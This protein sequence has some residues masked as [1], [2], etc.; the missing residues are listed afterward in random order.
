MSKIFEIL[1]KGITEN[2][3]ISIPVS[4][5][6]GVLS[7]LLSPCHLASIPLI[8]GFI[9]IQEKITRKIAFILSFFF[10]LGILI[11][12]TVIGITTSLAG[13]MLGDIGKTGNIIV[14]IVLLF[15]ALYLLGIF[16]FNISSPNVQ[17]FKK[18]GYFASF[19]LGLIF[20][21]ALGPCT[22]AYMA[23]ILSFTFKISSKNLIHGIFLL[24][25]YGIGHCS[26]IVFAGTFTEAVQEYL[27]WTDKS[28]SVLLIKKICGFFLLI[29]AFYL[30]LT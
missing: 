1:S 9:S 21:I 19:L 14:G 13:K 30:F 4:F 23:P 5:L 20:G 17:S 11:T 12:I 27:N 8:V 22:F 25:F 26:V 18:K 10:A 28:K 15:V 16:K 6:W 2:L 7:I 24:L 29:A 3:F